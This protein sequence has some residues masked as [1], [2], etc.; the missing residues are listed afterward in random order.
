MP[1]RWSWVGS[2]NSLL[3]VWFPSDVL[4]VA[5]I[6]IGDSISG[7]ML[8]DKHRWSLSVQVYDIQYSFTSSRVVNVSARNTSPYSQSFPAHHPY[9][10]LRSPLKLVFSGIWSTFWLR[11]WTVYSFPKKTFRRNL[12]HAKTLS[13]SPKSNNQRLWCFN[14]I[15]SNCTMCCAMQCCCYAN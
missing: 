7:L 1:V 8:V 11:R 4:F 10:S 13:V 14:R 5:P 2:A 3:I 9:T 12:N 6:L 15:L